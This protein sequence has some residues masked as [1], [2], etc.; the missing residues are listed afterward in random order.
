[1]MSPLAL[2]LGRTTR[3]TTPGRWGL[4]VLL[5]VGCSTLN[6]E[7][8]DVTCT[9]LDNG[10]E[11]ACADGIIATCQGGAVRWSVCEQASACEAAWQTVGRYRCAQSDPL[12]VLPAASGSGGSAGSGGSSG[13]AA[14]GGT[15]GRAVSPVAV[16]VCGS[17]PSGYR[18][19]ANACNRECGDCGCFQ[20][21]CVSDA[22]AQAGVSLGQNVCGENTRS[23]L[24]VPDCLGS[25]GSCGTR[26]LCVPN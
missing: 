10:A 6:R 11:N 4:V 24:S 1:M 18:M 14:Q 9:D 26:E 22:Q 23:V 20:Q 15:G 13:S 16:A 5:L 7:G 17:C 25:C 12:P 3:S 8:P 21:L 19:V 2:A